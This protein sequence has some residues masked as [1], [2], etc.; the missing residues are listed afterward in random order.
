MVEAVERVRARMHR[1]VQALDA[2]GVPFAVV[3]GNAV[4][5]W[6]A[7]VDEGAVRNTQDVDIL[8]RREDLVAAQQA[9]ATVGIVYRKARNLD[10]FLDGPDSKARDA[11]HVIF[12]RELVTP[13]SV[14]LAPDVDDSQR[15]GA[16]PVV[17]LEA[18]V[19]MKLTA[20]RLKDRVHLLD[21][22]EV[23]LLDSSWPSRLPETL[24]SR[25]QSLID[26]PDQ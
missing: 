21:L 15:L 19:G 23:G 16:I 26:N 12:A 1:A 9:L 4:A 18:L 22:L 13:D 7:Q 11:L 24:A 3:G 5:A 2:A 14:M 6:V 25:L 20:F 8:L 17:N 10:M